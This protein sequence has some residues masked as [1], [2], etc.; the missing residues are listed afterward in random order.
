MVTSNP[1]TDKCPASSTHDHWSDVIWCYVIPTTVAHIVLGQPWLY[2]IE[3][4][5]DGKENTKPFDFN[6]KKT[7]MAL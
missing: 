2:D 1:M 5:N 6:K 3:V 4:M 7:Q